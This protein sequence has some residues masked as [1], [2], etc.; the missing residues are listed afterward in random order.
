M[1]GRVLSI[2][3]NGFN[4]WVRRMKTVYYKFPCTFIRSLCQVYGNKIP[5]KKEILSYFNHRNGCS[6]LSTT[7]SAYSRVFPLT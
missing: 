4:I 5:T 1:I 7:S 2:L 3:F 6:P